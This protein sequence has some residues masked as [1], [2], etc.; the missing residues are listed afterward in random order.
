MFFIAFS[1]GMVKVVKVVKENRPIVYEALHTSS[2]YT[3]I[4]YIL[5]HH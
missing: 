1:L 3:P 2:P 5:S 4:I